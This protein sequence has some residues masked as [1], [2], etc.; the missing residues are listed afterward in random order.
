MLFL[1]NNYGQVRCPCNNSD[2]SIFV[3]EGQD[4]LVLIEMASYISGD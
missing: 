4:V 2:F 3:I 1:S